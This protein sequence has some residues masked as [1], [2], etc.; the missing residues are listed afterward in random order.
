MLNSNWSH[1]TWVLFCVCVSQLLRLQA[2]HILQLGHLWAGEWKM[3]RLNVHKMDVQ[4]DA[5]KGKPPRVSM[6]QTLGQD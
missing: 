1:D 2:L 6:E 3:V 4:P 5:G